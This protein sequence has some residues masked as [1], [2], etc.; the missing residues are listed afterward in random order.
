L[1]FCIVCLQIAKELAHPSPE[2]IVSHG[3]AALEQL[4]QQ[5]IILGLRS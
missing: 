1:G 5:G 4:R 3:H 2:T